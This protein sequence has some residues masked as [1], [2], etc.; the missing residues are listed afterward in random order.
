[1]TIY[2]LINGISSGEFDHQLKAMYGSSERNIM[3]NRARY[4]SAA[5]NFSRLY[6]ESVEIK[7]FSAG[8][9]VEIGG[10][11]TKRQGG[12][13]LAAAVDA[14]V[15]AIAAHNGMNKINFRSYIPP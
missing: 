9:A 7:V 1:M 15:I 4:L 10:G 14:D 8:G 11:F 12:R 13:V 2:D 6:P 5:E 3:K